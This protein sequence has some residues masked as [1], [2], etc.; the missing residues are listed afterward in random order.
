MKPEL[1]LEAKMMK[2]RLSYIG[3][4]MR[5]EDQLENTIILRK[6]EGSR[7]RGKPNM[8]QIKSTVLGIE[9]L[10]MGWQEQDNLEVTH[11]QSCHKLEFILWK[12]TTTTTTMDNNKKGAY[13]ETVLVKDKWNI[14]ILLRYLG[15]NHWSDRQLCTGVI[16][17][18][19][20]TQISIGMDITSLR[21]TR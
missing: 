10:S 19:I 14:L 21:K 6:Y 20:M 9:K 15:V 8:R 12:T 2:L 17:F 11:S 5:R 13:A 3:H 16:W 7:K 18:R 4:I 1:S